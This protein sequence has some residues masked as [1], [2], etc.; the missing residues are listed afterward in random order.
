MRANKLIIVLFF[1]IFF[2]GCPVTT[3][4]YFL[5][6]GRSLNAFKYIYIYPLEYKDGTI[7]TWGI[8]TKLSNHFSMKGLQVI[9]NQEDLKKLSPE[10]YGET[11]F[12]KI[13]HNYSW[14][15]ASCTIEIYDYRNQK[16]FNCIGTYQQKSVMIDQD[17]REELLGAAEEA[18][19][20]FDKSYTTFDPSLAINPVDELRK[21]TANWEKVDLNEEQLKSYFDK[22]ISALDPIEGI[23]TST[24]ENKYRIGILKEPKTKTRD[25]VAII[26]QAEHLVW[27]PKQVKIEFQ[28]TIYQKSYTTTY[29]MGDFSRQGTTSYISENGILQIPLKGPDNKDVSASFIKN[30]PN[31]EAGLNSNPF[32]SSSD[33]K[34]TSLGSGFLIS[35]SGIII[36]NWHVIKGCDDIEIFFPS[37]NKSYKATVSLKDAVNDLAIL[38]LSDFNY[39]NDFK[40]AIP[41]TLAQS[42]EIKLGQEVFTLGFPLGDI[43]GTKAKLSSGTVSSL[44]GIKDDPRLAQISNPIQPGNSGGPLFNRNGQ[45]IGVV[46][47]SLNAKYFFENA[48]ILPQNVNFAI[49]SDYLINL[50]SMLPEDEQ[51]HKRQNRLLGLSLEK[52]IESIAPFIVTVTAK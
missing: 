39:P 9:S 49:K 1:S 31:K 14:R 7:D 24:E 25:F 15:D 40:T 48:D 36:T 37:L 11:M 2:Y 45:I 47:A 12:C 16:I 6:P 27:Q 32:S 28:K 29:Y 44:F 3:S 42:K 50:C 34:S 18:F 8:A 38:R 41:F 51:I 22:N 4:D 43:L 19:K 26:I 10:Q 23:W 35:E 33:A 30:Y 5:Q 13:S 20:S 46:V 21:Q 52:Q 17:I